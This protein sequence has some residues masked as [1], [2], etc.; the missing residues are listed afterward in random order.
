MNI[1]TIKP[2][3]LCHIGKFSFVKHKIIAIPP[4]KLTTKLNKPNPSDEEAITRLG[5]KNKS[6]SSFFILK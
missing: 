2:I 4:P 1:I 3:N 6:R 5:I